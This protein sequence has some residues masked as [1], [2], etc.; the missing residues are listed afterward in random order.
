MS[1]TSKQGSYAHVRGAR[2]L[3]G[4]SCHNQ[5]IRVCNR[6]RRYPIDLLQAARIDV[7]ATRRLAFLER[8]GILS[9]LKRKLRRWLRER[10]RW[11]DKLQVPNQLSG[12]RVGK[13]ADALLAS[14][15]MS[16]DREIGTKQLVCLGNGHGDSEPV[17]SVIQG[18]RRYVVLAQP[19]IDCCG[20]LRGRSEI[21]RCLASG[22]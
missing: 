7:A 21:R 22:Q 9:H 19:S 16:E 3:T 14:R 5:R 18:A 4:V 8:A 1:A 13:R 12:D 11:V 10:R 2:P 20:S 15:V 17:P 6:R